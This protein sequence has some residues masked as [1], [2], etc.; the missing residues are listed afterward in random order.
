MDSYK[1]IVQF[2]LAGRYPIRNKSHSQYYQWNKFHFYN[3][4]NR[5]DF[6]CR[7]KAPVFRVFR[8]FP[9]SRTWTK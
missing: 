7:Y 3:H 8:Y 6:R 4:I 5:T 1:L 9:K 2:C